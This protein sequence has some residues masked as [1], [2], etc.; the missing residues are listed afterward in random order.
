MSSRHC[1]RKFMAKPLTI[2]VALLF[3]LQV[4]SIGREL[5]YASW[6]IRWESQQDIDEGNGWSKRKEPIANIIKFHDFDIIGLQEGSP[7]RLRDLM[8][9]LPDY[10][11]I[12]SDTMEYNP[13]VIRKGMFTVRDHGRFY[14][15]K[16]PE[17]KS[18]SWDSKHARYCTWAKLIFNQDTLYIFNVH[19]DYHG[20]EAQFESAK[21][22]NRKIFTMA[23]KA[24]FIFAGDLNFTPDSKS[25]QNLDTRVMSDAK[26]IAEFS[27]APNGSYNYFD[28]S[29]SSVWQFDHIFVAPGTKVKRF[30]ILNETYYDGEKFR[31]PSDH[32]PLMIRFFIGN[33]N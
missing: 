6:N 21:L 3:C 27:I 19:F 28:P 2:L 15:S 7:P 22:M 17:K 1:L 24:P 25:Y 32:S 31:Y 30:G 16:T 11:F 4:P 13:I 33:D 26:K 10:E 12:L 18:K 14:L 5:S 9:L 29:K 23:N 8:E 20:K